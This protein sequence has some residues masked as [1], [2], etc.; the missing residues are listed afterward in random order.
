MARS[1]GRRRKRN[2]RA[3]TAKL[4]WIKRRNKPPQFIPTLIENQNELD[5]NYNLRFTPKLE[6][7]KVEIDD[8]YNLQFIPKLEEI[9]VELDDK[10]NLQ[11]IP[12][13]EEKQDE[14][15]KCS[16]QFV[17]NLNSTPTISNEV[18]SIKEEWDD[19]AY[20]Y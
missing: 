16:L 15:S 19:E 9:Q 13:F 20:I 17:E 18:F 1:R 14:L 2:L 3:R 11:F 4:A 5:D 8:K 6:E 12:K 7:I 10:Y